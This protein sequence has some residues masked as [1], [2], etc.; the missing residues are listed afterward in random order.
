VTSDDVDVYF[1]LRNLLSD[2]GN[3]VPSELAAHP[4][5]KKKPVKGE[6][7]FGKNIEH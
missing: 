6:A 4:A 3:A 7:A 1:D 5:S 2:S